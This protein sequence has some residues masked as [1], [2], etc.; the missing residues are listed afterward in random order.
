MLLDSLQS[1]I[2]CLQETKLAGEAK[3][4][5]E[6]A[7]VDGYHAYFSHC[8]AATG[9]SLVRAGYAGTAT[10]VRSN[11]RCLS[12]AAC[13]GAPLAGP[14]PPAGV[15]GGGGGGH[16]GAE[17]VFEPGGGLPAEHLV[18]I[19][20]AGD[21]GGAAAEPVV[22]GGLFGR[23]GSGQRDVRRRWELDNEGRA[24]LT[25]HGGFVVVNVYCPAGGP[26]A[27]ASLDSIARVCPPPPLAPAHILP[28]PPASC[29][30]PCARR[31][32]TPC[33]DDGPQAGTRIGRATSWPIILRCSGGVS[34][35]GRA[36]GARWWWGI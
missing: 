14:A 10:Y 23:S 25:E 16:P 9:S 15:G 12:A 11:V 36:G 31:R 19:E 30:R 17:K 24:L 21:A 18:H 27:P 28:V 32:L 2:I 4:T 5:R 35:C 33:H 3:L 26:F 13:L 1:D 29:H 8:T 7:V 22:G 20:S 6:L 34:S